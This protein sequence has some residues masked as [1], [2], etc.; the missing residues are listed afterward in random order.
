MNAYIEDEFDRL[1][2]ERESLGSHR[3]PRRFSPWLLALAAVL[4]LAPLLGWGIG[5]WAASDSTIAEKSTQ[6]SSAEVQQ[7]ASPDQQPSQPG[8][9]EP[10]DEPASE[11][12][13]S[14]EQDAQPSAPPAQPE[15]DKTIGVLVLNGRGEAGLAAR[16]AQELADQG[17]ENV[18]PGDYSNARLPIDTTVYYRDAAHLQVAQDIAKNLG[19]VAVEDGTDLGLDADV[20][21]ILR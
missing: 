18:N 20:V 5:L 14:A 9:Q 12:P 1:A 10:A 4:V 3:Q 11:D 13:E 7:P 21:V 6:D 16:T 8:Q 2:Q 15:I 17:Y 19:N